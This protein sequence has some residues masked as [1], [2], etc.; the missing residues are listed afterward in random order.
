[1]VRQQGTHDAITGVT[2]AIF[3][4]GLVVQVCAL[5]VFTRKPLREMKL[6]AL[7]INVSVSNMIILLVECPL[8]LA[9]CVQGEIWPDNEV[10]CNIRGFVCGVASINT[11]ITFTSLVAKMMDLV[12]NIPSNS[13]YKKVLLKEKTLIVFSWVYSILIMLPTMAGWGKIFQDPSGLSCS[14]DWWTQTTANIS[15]LVVLNVLAFCLPVSYLVY[16]LISLWIYFANQKSSTSDVI[17]RNRT[18]YRFVQ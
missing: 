1:M 7:F 15:Y 10:L 2:I 5:Y 4:A 13:K 9:S 3:V 8:L 6:T 16:K 11:I 14:L 17:N 12:Q 18:M